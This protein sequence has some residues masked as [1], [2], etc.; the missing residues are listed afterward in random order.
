[1]D[2][3]TILFNAIQRTY[4]NAIVQHVRNRLSDE[5]GL[6]GIEKVVTLFGKRDPETGTSYWDGIKEAAR[7]RRSGGTGELSTPIQDDFELLG[8]EHFFNVFEA[9]FD[10]LCPTHALK[11]KKERNQA[12]QVL[13]AWMKHI[14]NVRDPISHPVADDINYDESAQVLFCA[15]KILD[16]CGLSDA[17][18]QILRLQSTLLGGVSG[19]GEKTFTVLPPED[20]VVMDFVGRHRELAVLADWLVNGRSQRWALAGEGGKGKSAIAYNFGRSVSSRDDHGLDAVLWMSAKRRRFVEG[21]TIVVDRPDFYDK[22]SATRAIVQF[23]GETTDGDDP[24]TAAL[25]LLFD[26]PS[27][28]IVDDI[29]TLE[30]DGED[31]IQFLVMTVPERTRSKVLLT[32][33]KAL[34]GLMNVTTQIE[35]LSPPDAEDF[36]K[37]RCDLMG[38]ETGA[39]LA[40]KEKLLSVTDR[41]P[42]Y[43]EDLLRLH[44]T[45]VSIDR[46]IGLWGEKRGA[47]ARK[48]AMQREYDRLDDDAKQVLLALSI[49]GRCQAD[50][51]CRGLDWS[52]ERLINAMSQLRKMFLMPSQKAAGP[53]NYLTLNRNTQVLVIDIFRNTEAYRRT[54]RLIKAATGSLRTKRSEDHEVGVLL[55]RAG[56]LVKQWRADEAEMEVQAATGRFPGRGD[57]FAALAWVQKK[58][59]DFASARL[60]FKR[61]HELRCDQRDLYW[62]WSDME[63]MN[64]EWTAS[65]KAAE[66][67]IARFGLDQ[68]LFFRLGYA[69]HRQGRELMREGE[70]AKEIC[71]RAHDILEQARDLKD[72][73]ARNYS[74]RNQ[75]YRAVALNLEALDDG[76]ELAKHF[77]KWLKDCPGDPKWDSEYQR[78][79]QRYPGHLIA[80]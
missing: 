36:L 19:G 27:L 49:H 4:R 22:A 46:A 11:P 21:T 14:K 20:E 30:S 64:E 16:F 7:E 10:V 79:R 45:G 43:I 74:L 52:E 37:S 71:R 3:T 29:D 54:D 24:E 68:G 66:L 59:S 8:V 28:L 5:F 76:R 55:D 41:S 34:F 33:R 35:G 44:Q 57:L 67:G 32:S 38:L 13:T 77:A 70:D 15:R 80:R 63:A 42:L 61:A 18:A 26:F 60:N 62:H 2:N 39:V 50:D 9:H 12:K 6:E 17:S 51:L 78:L 25:Q 53:G 65:A 73:E 72:C 58:R 69:L 56:F 1:M 40:M 47:E 48:Y 75:I 23:F 31:A